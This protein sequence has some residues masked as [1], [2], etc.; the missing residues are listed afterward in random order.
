ME[1]SAKRGFSLVEIL[2]V[3]VVM[4]ILAA[5]VVPQ[6]S[7]SAESARYTSTIHNLQDLREEIELFRNQHLGR[8]PGVAGADPDTV[9]AEQMTSPTNVAGERSQA[10]NQGFGD[11]NYPL[12]PYMPNVIPPNPFNGSRRV[13][14]V[15]SFPSAPPGGGSISDPGWIYEIKSGRIKINKDGV[16][17]TGQ[18][19]WDL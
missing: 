11:P 6:F 3:V 17:P 16:C 2:I 7:G 1:R 8:P 12:G 18:S 13:R 15:T 9:F 10:A 14:T 5:I 19:Y 4:G